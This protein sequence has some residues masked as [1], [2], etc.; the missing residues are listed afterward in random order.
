[1]DRFES[2]PIYNLYFFWCFHGGSDYLRQ[3]RTL[4]Y[5]NLVHLI[6]MVFFLFCWRYNNE[7]TDS[8]FY[9]SCLS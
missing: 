1:M 6:T 2:S 4:A 7:V 9:H 5:G 3:P 8:Y